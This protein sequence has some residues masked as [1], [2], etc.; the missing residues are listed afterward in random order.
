VTLYEPSVYKVG[1]YKPEKGDYLSTVAFLLFNFLKRYR[2]SPEKAKVSEGEE[3][4]N[5]KRQT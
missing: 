5:D 2:G 3:F 4:I 1:D